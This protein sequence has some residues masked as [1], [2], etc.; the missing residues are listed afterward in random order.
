[1]KLHKLKSKIRKRKKKRL[2]RGVGSG[3]GTYSG[4]GVKGQKAR[5][6]YKI[7]EPAS[8]KK[9]PQLR[10]KGFR[11]I[12]EEKPSVVNL[13]DL[14]KKYKAGEKVD[15]ESLIEKGLVNKKAKKVKILG[16]GKLT[17]KL[18]FSDELLFSKSVIDKIRIS[19][20]RNKEIKKEE[21]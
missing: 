7:P 9:L 11:K 1:M 14:E 2:G 8:W 20:E 21:K 19:N 4:R 15:L 3:K 6:G 10:G 12:K 5:S 18:K 17:K 13:E 16:R